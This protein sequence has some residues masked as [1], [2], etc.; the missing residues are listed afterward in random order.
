MIPGCAFW[1]QRFLAAG[2]SLLQKVQDA[3][4]R[5]DEARFQRRS[6]GPS[7]RA[8]GEI[9]D[10]YTRAA[11]YGPHPE[12]FARLIRRNGL[13]DWPNPFPEGQEEHYLIHPL[14]FL[15]ADLE[16]IVAGWAQEPVAPIPPEPSLWPTVEESALAAYQ[17]RRRDD[18]EVRAR[19]RVCWAMA[20][21]AGPLSRL[22]RQIH[23]HNLLAATT[24]AVLRG[25]LHE[26]GLDPDAVWASAQKQGWAPD[27][28]AR[29]V[30][31]KMGG[32]DLADAPMNEPTPSR[33]T[34]RQKNELDRLWREAD[35][36][37]RRRFP[38][39]TTAW[40]SV[41]PLVLWLMLFPFVSF[42]VSLGAGVIMIAAIAVIASQGWRRLTGET[43]QDSRR[44]AREGDLAAERAAAEKRRNGPPA[45]TAPP[46][47]PP[48]RA[49]PEEGAEESD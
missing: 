46:P 4:I 22:R 27:L 5:H 47:E 32:P 44:R 1:C 15:A 21:M 19:A 39:S 34:L 11:E 29:E 20:V 9:L 23:P 16:H 42:E 8:M 14:G 30:W 6:H 49:A 7:A 12:A 38:S 26:F 13:P 25:P 45:R 28:K 2:G 3:W 31:S 24:D 43:S 41:V 35:A 10:Y 33:E 40:W 18:K 48:P 37:D 36:R 17:A